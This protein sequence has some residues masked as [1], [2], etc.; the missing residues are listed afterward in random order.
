[1]NEKIVVTYFTISNPPTKISMYIDSI[2]INYLDIESIIQ[3]MQFK[4]NYK[5]NTTDAAYE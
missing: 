4:L 5:N 2:Y 3:I 1:M